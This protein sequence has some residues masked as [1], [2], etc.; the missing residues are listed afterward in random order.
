MIKNSINCITSI[1]VFH[2]QKEVKNHFC[3]VSLH[4]T[5]KG[6][7]ESKAQMAGAYPDF[8][9]MKQL[10]VLP[11]PPLDRMLVHCR[12]TLQQS[13]AGTHLYTC[14]GEERQSK[15]PCLRK[16]RDRPGLN[17]RPPDPE[18]EVF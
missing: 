7:H 2:L 15:V 8:I 4:L 13:V 18:F 1:T 14:M 12:V 9:S 10:R 17:P 16:Q 5:S 3:V 11:L 6:A